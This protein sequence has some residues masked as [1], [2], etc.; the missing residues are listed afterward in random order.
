MHVKIT[1]GQPE[2]YDVAHL[3]RDNPQ[4]SFPS[5]LTAEVLASHDIYELMPTEKPSVD[6][7]KNVAEGAPVL[8]GVEWRQGWVVTDAS[9]DEIAE[10]EAAEWANLRKARNN[11][12]A[13]CD[14]T[15]VADSQVDKAAWAAYRQ[16]LRDL[17]SNTV[18][19]FNP[20][21]PQEP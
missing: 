19:P 18:D 9:A 2:K 14:W 12:L 15:Q 4:V 8:V 3:R 11:K 7:T 6:H 20:T 1:N 17:P 10:R 21:W 13:K 5:N 16:A